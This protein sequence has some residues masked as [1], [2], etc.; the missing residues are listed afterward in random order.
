MKYEKID[1]KKW[2]ATVMMVTAIFSVLGSGT[3]LA[4]GTAVKTTQNHLALQ[5]A[6]HYAFEE[7]DTTELQEYTMNASEAEGV[8]IID[9][10]QASP[11]AMYNINVTL[12]NAIYQSGG[13]SASTGDIVYIQ[14]MADPANVNFK[15]GIM[16]PNGVWRYVYGPGELIKTF[17]ITMN[18]THKVFVWNETTTEIYVIGG[19]RVTTAN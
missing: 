3:A 14:V 18:G 9:G 2:I 13:F 8:E 1:R 5:T 16:Q 4:A 6:V 11:L 10:S 19:Y 12:K 17:E 15:A 7:D